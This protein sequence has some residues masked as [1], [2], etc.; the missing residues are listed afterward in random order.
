[1]PRFVPP[2]SLRTAAFG[3]VVVSLAAALATPAVA[4]HHEKRD[5]KAVEIAERSLEAMGGAEAWAD[6]RYV[7][8]NF[9]GFRLH[10]W[11][12]HT[13]DHRLEGKNRE[14]QEYVV[15]HNIH[16]GGKGAGHVWLDGEALEGDD[17]AQWLGNAYGAWINDAYWLV[18][19]YKLLDPGVNLA[20]DGSEELDGT[21]YDKLKLTFQGVGLTPG[22]TYWAYIDRDTGLMGRW[23]Y[24]LESFKEGQEPTAWRWTDW[25]TYGD[26]K[27]SSGREKV[28]DG[29]VREL[30]EI[31]VLDSLPATAFTAR[32][33]AP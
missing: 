22:D 19:P 33:I 18:M 12:R 4:E 26:V 16:D 10:H 28:D 6:T 2:S 17:R 7:R 30:G 29:A 24:S 20:Y 1:M 11:D 32:V 21:T 31:A 23:A 25:Q 8:F 13:G 3:L 5:P 9:F 14:G 15:V 27:L